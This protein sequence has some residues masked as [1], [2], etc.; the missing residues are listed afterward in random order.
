MDSR[1]TAAMAVR[2]FIFDLDGVIT[3][4]AE[5]H[6]RGWKRLA[7][8]M[9]FPF[10]RAA[11]EQLRG[12]SRRE[13][14]LRLLGERASQFTE[15]KLQD[16][17]TRKNAYYLQSIQEISPRDM[18]PGARELLQELRA[19]HFKIAL[20]SASKNARHVLRSLEIE[21]LFDAVADGYSVER[22]KPAPDLFLFAAK[23]LQLAP[24]ECVVV[25][26][27][28]AGIEA[29]KAGGFYAVGLGPPERVGGADAVFP[30]LENVHVANVLNALKQ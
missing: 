28:A 7:D 24:G 16:M 1:I 9:G 2:G 30:N 11:N 22:H 25:E 15:D 20:G 29:A 23:A 3:D 21:K 18:L 19:A 6:Y 17:M 8:E 14:L 5:F 10:D 13:S 4:T 26:D 27:A 12:V